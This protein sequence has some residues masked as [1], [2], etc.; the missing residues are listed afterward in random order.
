M[1][2]ITPPDDADRTT[3]VSLCL[4]QCALIVDPKNGHLTKLAE[5]LD[6]HSVTL[7]KWI[8]DGRVPRKSAKRLARRFGKKFVDVDLLVGDS[9]E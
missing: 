1:T 7:S 3:I 5:H 9:N 8:S 6:L 2:P 4:R